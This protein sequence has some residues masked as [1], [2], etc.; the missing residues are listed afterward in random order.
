MG[1]PRGAKNKQSQNLEAVLGRLESHGDVSAPQ[2]F[3]NLYAIA[4]DPNHPQAVAAARA[5]LAYRLGLP[6]ASVAFEHTHELSVENVLRQIA[7]ER[8]RRIE[9]VE[10]PG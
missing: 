7:E 8:R 9:A 4:T 5:F 6:K 1:R 3:R 2:V 10:E